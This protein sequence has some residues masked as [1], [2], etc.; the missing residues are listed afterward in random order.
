MADPSLTWSYTTPTV[1]GW[2]WWQADL[3]QPLHIVELSLNEGSGYWQIKA[4]GLWIILH[5][6]HGR[7]CGPIPAPY[8]LEPWAPTTP[9]LAPSPSL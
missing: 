6:A 3:A 1:E 7:F 5:S 9:F 4:R 2:Y 8:A